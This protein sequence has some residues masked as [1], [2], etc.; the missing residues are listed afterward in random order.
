[1]LKAPIHHRF[2]SPR[3]FTQQWRAWTGE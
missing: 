1:M 3:L 2:S